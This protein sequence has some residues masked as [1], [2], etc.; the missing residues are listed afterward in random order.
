MLH[1]PEWAKKSF[2]DAATMECLCV[3]H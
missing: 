1:A 2:H 3:A